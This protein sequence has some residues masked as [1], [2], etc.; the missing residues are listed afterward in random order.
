ML[1][2]YHSGWRLEVDG[3]RAGK[4]E[5]YGGFLSAEAQAGAHTYTFVYDPASFRI[6]AA[7]TIGTIIGAVLLL[8]SQTVGPWLRRRVLNTAER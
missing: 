6:G 7:I 2:S 5:S 4:P 8:A 3:E 1:E